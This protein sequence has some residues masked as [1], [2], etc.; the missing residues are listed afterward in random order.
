MCSP[1]NNLPD[2]LL[3][4]AIAELRDSPATGPTADVIEQTLARI[5]AA[6]ASHAA[7]R[8]NWRIIMKPRFSL[9]AAAIVAVAL[10]GVFWTQFFGSGNVALGQV[11]AKVNAV[12]S[13][14]FKS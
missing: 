2:D 10:L 5:E 4:K 7:P 6:Q 1:S 14:S 12:R 9:A 13:V 8:L 11:I 3:E